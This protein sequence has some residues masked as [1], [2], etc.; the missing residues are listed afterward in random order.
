MPVYRQPQP[1]F[2]HP[3]PPWNDSSHP[4]VQVHPVSSHGSRGNHGNH[5][6]H[7][8]YGNRS[9]GGGA[10]HAFSFRAPNNPPFP[11][12]QSH[13]PANFRHGDQ[14]QQMQRGSSAGRAS[15]AGTPNSNKYR[16]PRGR[17]Q[18]RARGGYRPGA[19]LLP[20]GNQSQSNRPLML[21]PRRSPTPEQ[22]E[23][24]KD[25][26]ARFK[27]FEDLTDSE[28]T[29]MD[30][31]SS[32]AS[33]DPDADAVGSADVG[34]MPKRTKTENSTA[35]IPSDNAPR[36][37]NPAPNE[38][39]ATVEGQSKKK[40]LIRLLRKARTG[41]DSNVSRLPGEQDFISF[42]EKSMGPILGL[43]NNL[44]PYRNAINATSALLS[45]GHS[46]PTPAVSAPQ[47]V[48]NASRPPGNN[49]GRQRR[50][51]PSLWDLQTSWAGSTV[52]WFFNFEPADSTHDPSLRL[53]KEILVF[54]NWVKPSQHEKALRESIISQNQ[55]FFNEI[56]PG[57]QVRAYGSFPAGMYLP[58]AD[59][60]LVVLSQKFQTQGVNS[61]DNSRD[62][63]NATKALR[64]AT[65]FAQPGT[66]VP[67]PRAKVPIVKFLDYRTRLNID[68]SFD[69]DSGIGALRT[70][71]EWNALY[72]AMPILVSVIKQFL[73]LRG[74]N[75]VHSGGI[76]GFAI[77]CL[78]VHF[79]HHRQELSSEDC[80]DPM[81]DLGNTLMMF[82][83]FYGNTFD[84]HKHG[85][86]MS[87][88]CFFDKVNLVDLTRCISCSLLY[89]TT[90]I[91]FSTR[92]IAQIL[93][94]SL[95]RTARRTTF[96]PGATAMALSSSSF[97]K[98]TQPYASS[99]R[100]IADLQTK[101]T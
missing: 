44:N 71:D 11:R 36:W 57:C 30:T 52:P 83:S 29:P 75:E 54:Y 10:P 49:A 20:S 94:R 59:M 28:N 82:L 21:Q 53:H 67:I 43:L 3:L 45:R 13:P 46:G 65:R 14:Q 88:L 31:D 99:C 63:R 24:M 72:P 86:E 22:Y 1:P 5:G 78:V 8:N 98:R 42:S 38:S 18:P 34:P 15:N 101:T 96:R 25:G 84:C 56:F 85:L 32:E 70:I 23:A 47:T 7:G 91:D 26:N 95:T 100:S 27:K 97:P 51:E 16:E 60:D 74:L 89:S 58:T 4:M 6:N 39:L 61:I 37:S 62:I 68:V 40:D 17:G 92:E 87:P 73:V 50:G 76:G 41:N 77:I 79:L 9:R 90:R 64:N 48:S 80:H 55:T 69:N 66:V 93:C 2:G 12:G 19:P 33:D 35:N 81:S